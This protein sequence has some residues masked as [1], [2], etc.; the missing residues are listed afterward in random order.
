[1]I[2]LNRGQRDKFQCSVD[3][4]VIDWKIRVTIYDR[5][6]KIQKKSKTLDGSAKEISLD[7]QQSNIFYIHLKKGETS[8]FDK[9]CE[10]DLELESPDGKTFTVHNDKIMIID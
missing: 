3:H 9:Q 10:F 1:M 6:L 7:S 2:E 5:D 4:S 8:D